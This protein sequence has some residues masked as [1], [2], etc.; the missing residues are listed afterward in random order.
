MLFSWYCIQ[1]LKFLFKGHQS[2]NT[3]KFS[4]RRSRIP[5]ALVA[6]S[7]QAKASMKRF[8]KHRFSRLHCTV[9]TSTSLR[10]DIT[11]QKP[12]HV[13]SPINEQ[14]LA[15]IFRRFCSDLRDLAA[16]SSLSKEEK[17]LPKSNLAS[18]HPREGAALALPGRGLVCQP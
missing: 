5:S 7:Q 2:K 6:D 8:N 9:G 11:S 12:L 16:H 13:W 10:S 14:L 3:C 17:D 15:N 4:E 18:F 1:G